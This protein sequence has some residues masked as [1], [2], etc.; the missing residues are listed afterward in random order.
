MKKYSAILVLITNLCCATTLTKVCQDALKNDPKYK[1]AQ[2]E[3]LLAQEDIPSAMSSLLPDLN[4]HWGGSRSSI[5]PSTAPRQQQN[6]NSFSITLSQPIFDAQ[7]LQTLSQ[8]KLKVKAARAKLIAATQDLLVNTA[9]QYFNVV[10]AKAKLK[11]FKYQE[12]A[13]LKEYILSKKHYKSGLK[14]KLNLYEAKSNYDNIKA[15]RIIAAN[16]LENQKEYL[17][18]ITNIKYKKI[19]VLGNN[20]PLDK[21]NNKKAWIKLA[22]N[23]NYELRSAKISYEAAKEGLYIE[24]FARLPKLNLIGS[25]SDVLERGYGPPGFLDLH[26]KEYV[27]GLNVD[28][29]IYDGGKISSNTQ[30]AKANILL[31]QA[32]KI[33]LE[34]QIK[35]ETENYFQN[36][37]ADIKTIYARKT[38]VK[39]NEINMKETLLAYKNGLRTLNDVAIAQANLRHAQEKYIISRY[40]YILNVLLLKQAAGML[41]YEDIVNIDA[42]LTKNSILK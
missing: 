11:T 34:R 2:A 30:K 19:K 27:I 20:I 37:L 16:E 13:A 9:Q 24:A 33:K 18:Q 36:I 26:Y 25:Y 12:R 5:D 8:A 32:A 38:A 41:S 14:N 35:A 28:A 40:N 39:S 42:W 7:A 1:Q 23:H 31:T 21:P 17:T 22:Q 15:D 4:L 10:I 29:P 6:S 3:W